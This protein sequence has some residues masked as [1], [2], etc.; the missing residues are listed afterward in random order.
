[1]SHRTPTHNSKPPQPAPATTTH[2]TQHTTHNTPNHNSLHCWSR[3][4]ANGPTAPTAPDTPHHPTQLSPQRSWARP[5]HTS[6]T[7]TSQAHSTQGKSR[8]LPTPMH[9]P[10]PPHASADGADKHGRAV[11][12]GTAQSAHLTNTQTLPFANRLTAVCRCTLFPPKLPCRSALLHWLC[13][14]STEDR[15]TY[16]SPPLYHHYYLNTLILPTSL[17]IRLQSTTN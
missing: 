14:L 6:A 17:P 4:T 13:R 10:G 2:D 3:N 1:M 5:S 15:P 8:R 9:Q 12:H 11:H 7:C 16:R